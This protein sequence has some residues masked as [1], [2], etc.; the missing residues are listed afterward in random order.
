[1]SISSDIHSDQAR[2][3]PTTG[4]RPRIL[5]WIIGALLVAGGAGLVWYYEFGTP[6]PQTKGGFGKGGPGGFGGGRRPGEKPPV[7]V[8]SAEQRSIGVALRGLG[9]V[10]P[11]NTV[12]VR[13]RLDGELVRVHFTEGQRVR[14]GQLLAEIDARPYEVALQ[15]ALGTKA[16]NDARLANA[17]ADLATYQSLSERE[18]IP[19]QQMTAQE[20]LVKQVIGAVQSNDAQVANARLQLS[21]T[22]ITAPIS[23][24]LGLRQVDVGNLVRSGDANGIVVITQVQPISV[25]FT[26]PETELPAVL[27]AMRRDR[28]Q[29]ERARDVHRVVSL[30][31]PVALPGASPTCARGRRPGAAPAAPLAGAPAVPSMTSTWMPSFRASTPSMTTRSP[32]FSPSVIATRSFSAGPSVTRRTTALLS[33][34]MT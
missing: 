2:P 15:Q 31:A 27:A 11:I 3:E 26:V 8:V 32:A 24:R 1:M 6:A 13:S 25:L 12:T 16:E 19:R 9:T 30:A 7:R 29:D 4:R 34:S 22:R 10:T 23:G 18:L 5:Q 17:R 20:A 14:E 21:Y 28:A 33:P